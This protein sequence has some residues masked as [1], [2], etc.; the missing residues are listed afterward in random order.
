MTC[1]SVI[2]PVIGTDEQQG[3][4]AI[5]QRSRRDGRR[6]GKLRREA[7]QHGLPLPGDHPG[8]RRTR[9]RRIRQ[10]APPRHRVLGPGST[11][12]LHDPLGIG[13]RS[14]QGD[15]FDGAA[16]LH[17]LRELPGG[18]LDEWRQRVMS[19]AGVVAHRAPCVPPA[20]IAECTPHWRLQGGTRRRV[21]RA[22]GVGDRHHAQQGPHACAHDAPIAVGGMRACAQQHRL[23]LV[24][25]EGDPRPMSWTLHGP[26]HER[27]RRASRLRRRRP[28]GRR[29]CGRCPSL[30]SRVQPGCRIGR[31]RAMRHCAGGLVNS[32]GTGEAVRERGLS[33]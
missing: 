14:P 6:R 28:C 33:G 1:C 8:S 25:D 24:L 13:N 29:P 16:A 17:E 10:G 7:R 19:G 11:R 12:P 27:G 30:Q 22:R 2:G 5:G 18:A 32:G 20:D 15:P 9:W 26:R 4:N 31:A 23:P 21:D 3:C